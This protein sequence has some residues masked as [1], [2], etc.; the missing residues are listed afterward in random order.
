MK[1]NLSILLF[2]FIPFLAL[3]QQTPAITCLDVDENGDVTVQWLPPADPIGLIEYEIYYDNGA[4]YNLEGSVSDMEL[5][6]FHSGAQADLQSQKYY[7]AAVYQTASFSS[8]TVQSIFL[9][10]AVSPDFDE[11][12]LYWN[13][14]SS[15]L[16]EGSSN[17]YYIYMENG[18]DNWILIDSATAEPY[19]KIV[20]VCDEWVNFRVV[21]SNMNGCDSRSNIRGEQ[22]KDIILPEK[23]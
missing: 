3:S 18:A 4:G 2:F 20:Y 12:T 21:L 7:V 11:A 1:N 8:E 10:V 22:F 5:S 19:K 6:F 23:P 9:Q 17:Q 13:P 16:P 14:P 15:P